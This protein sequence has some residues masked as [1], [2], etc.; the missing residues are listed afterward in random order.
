MVAINPGFLL[1]RIWES[2]HSHFPG[3]QIPDGLGSL[4]SVLQ[5]GWSRCF[6]DLTSPLPSVVTRF[7]PRAPFLDPTTLAISTL[8][9]EVS[10]PFIQLL[11]CATSQRLNSVHPDP[12]DLT[13]VVLPPELYFSEPQRFLRP[14]FRCCLYTYEYVGVV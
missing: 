13:T 14:K 10:P 1:S 12:F 3:V 5:I 7:K 2:L 11:S 8:L 4:T 6:R 9:P